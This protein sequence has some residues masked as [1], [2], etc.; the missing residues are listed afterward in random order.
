MIPSKLSGAN[1]SV[2]DWRKSSASGAEHNCVEVA[3]MANG[4]KLIRD[5]KKITHGLLNCP[6]TQWRIF[7]RAVR[8][9]MWLV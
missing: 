6:K 3:E 5:S 9:G 4:D 1:Y 2:L 8:M 7:C